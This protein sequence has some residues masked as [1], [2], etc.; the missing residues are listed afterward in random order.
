MIRKEFRAGTS[1]LDQLQQQ[2]EDAERQQHLAECQR[3]LCPRDQRH[4]HDRL[5]KR[6]AGHQEND[7]VVDRERD[8]KKRKTDHRIG[9]APSKRTRTSP[10]TRTITSP[11]GIVFPP[12]GQI[13][14]HGLRARLP[15]QDS[16]FF[17]TCR[18]LYMPVFWSRW[19]GRGSSP[20][21]LSSAYVG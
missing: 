10:R 8:Q 3:P 5:L 21:S 1:P 6:N 16:F 13:R 4:L 11:P 2:Q 7:D 17:S 18:P 9:K 20:E 15:D 12:A 14:P 19:C